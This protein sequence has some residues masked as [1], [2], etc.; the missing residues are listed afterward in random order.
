MPGTSIKSIVNNVSTLLTSE[1]EY[2]K[3]SKATNPFG[4]GDACKK[5]VQFIAKRNYKNDK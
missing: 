2:E 1:I 3:M 4:C 5:I